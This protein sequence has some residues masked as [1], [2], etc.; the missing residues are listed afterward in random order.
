VEIRERVEDL[1][2]NEVA[3]IYDIEEG[4]KFHITK[5]EFVG[6]ARFSD[7][8]LKKVMETGEK[9]LF[10][11]ITKSGLLD[12]K[13]LEADVEKITAFT[14]IKAIFAP[15]PGIPKSPMKTKAI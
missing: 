5:I 9:G 15:G 7:R 14:T 6:N 1:P 10:S 12:E 3:L 2:G 8:T 4:P 13:K 11:W